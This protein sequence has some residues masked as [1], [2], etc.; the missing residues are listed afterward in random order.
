MGEVGASDDEVTRAEDGLK[1]GAELAGF[2]GGELADDNGDDAKIRE[3]ELEEGEFDFERVLAGVGRGDSGNERMGA[4]GSDS[5]FVDGDGAEGGFVGVEVIYRGTADV[6]VM[7]GTEDENA[8]DGLILN[9]AEGVGGAE[10]GVGV[11]GVRCDQ[12]ADGDVGQND[13][14]TLKV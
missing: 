4:E 6:D 13:V 14:D 2:V 10:A 9:L 11:A 3:D 12:C 7:R 5:V 8:F 1:M